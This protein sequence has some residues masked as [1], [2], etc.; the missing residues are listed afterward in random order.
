[1]HCNPSVN[2]SIQMKIWSFDSSHECSDRLLRN[3]DCIFDASM[4]F[5]KDAGHTMY[6]EDVYECQ[7]RLPGT[8]WTAASVP[9]TD[10]V[11]SL[12]STYIYTVQLLFRIQACHIP[13]NET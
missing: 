4:L 1:M 7:S 3:C 6:M 5:D 13:A 12:L 2:V 8:N 9:W 10:V 11:R